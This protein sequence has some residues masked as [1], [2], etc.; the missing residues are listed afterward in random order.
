[1]YR[2]R[3]TRS[4]PLTHDFVEEAQAVAIVM[5]ESENAKKPAGS[6]GDS[7]VKV[8]AVDTTELTD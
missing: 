3:L 5:Q 4:G 2:H 7:A 8:A 6:R 1:M